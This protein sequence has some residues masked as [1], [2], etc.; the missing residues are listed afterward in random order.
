M[1]SVGRLDLTEG[2]E[3]LVHKTQSEYKK[4]IVKDGKLTGFLSLGDISNSGLYL[5][6]IK[7]SIDISGKQNKIFRLSFAD[8][9][10][11]NQKNGEFA[12]NI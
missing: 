7:N 2:A 4:A 8:F 3:I 11:I 1:L 10:G 9:Y 12:Y 6:L 5:Y